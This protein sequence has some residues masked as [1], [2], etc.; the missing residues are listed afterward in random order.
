[1]S[2]SD[3]INGSGGL[4]IFNCNVF[5]VEK[6]L[7]IWK[8]KSESGWLVSIHR[9]TTIYMEWTRPIRRLRARRRFSSGRYTRIP[10]CVL[11]QT[12]YPPSWPDGGEE[13]VVVFHFFTRIVG[14]EH[15][16]QEQHAVNKLVRTVI[17]ATSRF[18]GEWKKTNIKKF[19]RN[20]W[21]SV[22]ILR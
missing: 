6:L 17:S 12:V 21:E 14:L 8:K 22:W 2:Y 1:M 19:E 13:L 9:T 20:M 4:L 5:F 16:E 3:V 18:C 10:L 11:E 7:L 15:G